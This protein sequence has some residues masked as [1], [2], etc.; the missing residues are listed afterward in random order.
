MIDTRDR[1]LYKGCRLKN[2]IVLVTRL[3]TVV[4]FVIVDPPV[5][6]S[7]PSCGCC[8]DVAFDTCMDTDFWETCDNKKNAMSYYN[9]T[10]I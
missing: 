6:Q 1:N 8:L 3:E 5:V 4:R 7:K 9:K 2:Q 10:K